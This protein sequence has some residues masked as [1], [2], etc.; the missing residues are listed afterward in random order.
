MI[1]GVTAGDF[2]IVPAAMIS[3]NFEISYKLGHLKILPATLSVKA[4]DTCNIPG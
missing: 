2:R 4:N 1:T 3:E